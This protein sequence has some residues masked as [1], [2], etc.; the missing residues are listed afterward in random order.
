[1]D[2]A[3][4]ADE[5]STMANQESPNFELLAEIARLER[6]EAE[7]SVR[8]RRLLDRMDCAVPSETL[9]DLERR[10]SEERHALHRR[11]ADLHAQLASG[12]RRPA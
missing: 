12:I 11:I 1:M 4:Y 10:V 5:A 9:I 6:E 2:E 3:L 8:R 7:L